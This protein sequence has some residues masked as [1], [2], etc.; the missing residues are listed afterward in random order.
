M[1]WPAGLPSQWLPLYLHL[2]ACLPGVG[3]ATPLVVPFLLVTLMIQGMPAS[4][5][6]LHPSLWLSPAPPCRSGTLS[7]LESVL[8]LFPGLPPHRLHRFSCGHV[9]AR[10]R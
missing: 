6:P 5:A 10:E 8:H 7:P 4:I 2:L 9:M 1:C 3:K